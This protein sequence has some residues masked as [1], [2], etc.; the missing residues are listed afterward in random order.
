MTSN[1]RVIASEAKQSAKIQQVFCQDF[2]VCF[3]SLARTA[4]FGLDSEQVYWTDF[5][6]FV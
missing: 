5:F 1:E 2:A 3:A 4:L 6:W